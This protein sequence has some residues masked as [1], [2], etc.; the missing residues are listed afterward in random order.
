MNG[1]GLGCLIFV[2]LV[3]TFGGCCAAAGNER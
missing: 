2:L 3:L 1:F